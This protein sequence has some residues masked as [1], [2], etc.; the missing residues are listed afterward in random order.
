VPDAVLLVEGQRVG[1]EHCELTEQDLAENRPNINS[2]E[3]TLRN[4]LEKL[5]LGQDFS[6]GVGLN[7]AAPLF[8]KRSQVNK[9][10]EQI[11]HLTFAQISSL[12]VGMTVEFGAPALARHGFTDLL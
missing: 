8:R 10:A 4:E 11:A 12:S 7:A 9:L 2:L 6:V 3:L 5:G 1:L